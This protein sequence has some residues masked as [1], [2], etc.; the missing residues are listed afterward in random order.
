MALYPRE[1]DF[2]SHTVQPPARA[3]APVKCLFRLITLPILGD[4]GLT[5]LPVGSSTMVNGQ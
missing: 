2:M 1:G 3:E 5:S 4:E